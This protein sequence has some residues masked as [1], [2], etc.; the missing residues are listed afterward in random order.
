MNIYEAKEFF[1]KMH[2]NNLVTFSFDDT[3]IRHLECVMT[4]GLP[5]IVHHVEYNKLKA[6]VQGGSD[7]YIPI[8]SHRE[9]ISWVDYQKVINAKNEVHIH[10]DAIKSFKETKND[11]EKSREYESMISQFQTLSGMTREAIESKIQ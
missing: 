3:C 2:P 6:S 8:Q 9:N 1:K 11:P 10:P 4:E 7:F 5:N